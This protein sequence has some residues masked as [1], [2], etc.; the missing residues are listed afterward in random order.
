MA[1]L[2]A[3]ERARFIAESL[4][5]DRGLREG[6]TPRKFLASA[7]D[8]VV[9]SYPKSGKTW[10]SYMATTYIVNYLGADPNAAEH[11][12]RKGLLRTISPESQ[13]RFVSAVVRNRTPERWAPL[14]QFAHH[15]QLGIPYFLTEPVRPPTADRAVLLLRD[16]RDIVVSHFHHK[17]VKNGGAIDVAKRSVSLPEDYEIGEFIRSDYLGIRHVLAYISRWA[18]WAQESGAPVFYYEDFVHRPR[19]TLASFVRAIGMSEAE[20][21]AIAKAVD[22]NTFSR[23]RD[24]EEKARKRSGVATDDGNRRMRRGKPGGFADELSAE[25]S[26]Y[27]TR[28]MERSGIA[29]IRRYLA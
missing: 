15:D 16:P 24:A 25:D 14:L 26:A 1:V 11:V 23:L 10:L 6:L 8:T 22:S 2:S 20:P 7:V 5:K 19:E 4:G 9:L 27:M 12:N 13:E 29:A 28:V 18:S 3:A 17:V 21:A